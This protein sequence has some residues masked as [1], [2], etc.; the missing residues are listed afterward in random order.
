VITVLVVSPPRPDVEALEGRHPSVEIL[1]A[2][3]ADGALEKLGRNRRI[4][5][6]LLLDSRPRETAREILGDN[7]AACP[8]YVPGEADSAGVRALPSG[9]PSQMIDWIAADLAAA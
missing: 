9:T 2:R 5:A 6:V 8:L 4:D 3:D 7:P 1:L